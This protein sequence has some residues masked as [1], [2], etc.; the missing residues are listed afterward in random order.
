MRRKSLTNFFRRLGKVVL[1]PV[2]DGAVRFR[3][4][5]SYVE[6]TACVLFVL[7]VLFGLDVH[8]VSH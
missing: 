5:I 4:M 7:F 3:S 2:C 6:L 1:P 8:M